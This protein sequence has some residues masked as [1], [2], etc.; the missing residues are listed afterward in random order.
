MKTWEFPSE[1]EKMDLGLNA[2]IIMNPGG[3]RIYNYEI[4]EEVSSLGGKHDLRWVVDADNEIDESDE[5]N[6]VLDI[7]L[8]WHKPSDLIVEGVWAEGVAAGGQKSTWKIKVKNIGQGPVITP[9]LTTFFPEVPGG[10]QENFW[11]SSLDAGQTITFTSTQRFRCSGKRKIRTTVDVG[12]NIPEELPKGENNNERIDEFDLTFVDLEVL[13]LNVNNKPE[14]TTFSIQLKNK[15]SGDA[16]QPFKVKLM[17][18]N[19]LRIFHPLPTRYE[20]VDENIGKIIY[21]DFATVEEI[22]QPVF[23]PV[24]GLKAGEVIILEHT[25]K[26]KPGNYTIR[27]EADPEIVYQEP[28]SLNNVLVNNISIP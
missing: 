25:V 7:S 11:T 19:V 21:K 16:T 1:A 24:S 12:N 23:L 15:G 5:K 6:N 27:I 10:S 9:F 8:I 26:L 22:L 4:P 20:K 13:N 14:G 3:T 17:P 2:T 18:G 28:D